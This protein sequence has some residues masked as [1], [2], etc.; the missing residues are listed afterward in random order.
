MESPNALRGERSG[1]TYA[2]SDAVSS[3]RSTKERDGAP[4]AG[5]SLPRREERDGRRAHEGRP[6][7]Q[8]SGEARRRMRQ[9]GPAVPEDTLPRPTARLS[10]EGS[11][12]CERRKLDKEGR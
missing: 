8:G 3:A 11:A 7:W 4:A 12:G 9:V 5:G 6:V 10:G 2:T 1:D